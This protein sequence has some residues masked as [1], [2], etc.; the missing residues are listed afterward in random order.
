MRAISDINMIVMQNRYLI[1]IKDRD[2][3][4]GVLVLRY[5]LLDGLTVM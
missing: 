1:L 4:L 2:F 5:Y 3:T